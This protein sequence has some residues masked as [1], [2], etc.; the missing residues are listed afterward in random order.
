MNPGTRTPAS[1]RPQ[2][3]GK[4]PRPRRRRKPPRRR[5]S[6]QAGSP[7]AMKRLQRVRRKLIV[8]LVTVCLIGLAI[9]FSTD[10]I[11]KVETLRIVNPDG[12]E[13]PDT[14][15]YSQEE[16]AQATGLVPGEA[17]FGV[18]GDKIEQDLLVAL[19][20]LESVAVKYS[21]PTTIIL[22]V[23]PA[24]ES[25]YM[26]LG[27]QYAILSETLRVLRITDTLPDGLIQLQATLGGEPQVGY[28]LDAAKVAAEDETASAEAQ[29]QNQTL[30]QAL[31]ELSQY[32]HQEDLYNRV[33]RID[34]QD[35]ENI[36]VTISDRI[37]IQLGTLNN[38]DYKFQMVG[39]IFHNQGEDGLTENDVG[40]LD[41]SNSPNTGKAYYTPQ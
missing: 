32:L 15:I 11:F 4:A 21:L 22:E 39:T 36:T 7:A 5:V 2:S 26:P 19:P 33:T 17:L 12:T 34:L 16:I 31:E 29:E 24:V 20:Y 9:L 37:T 13:P 14:G 1:S 28:S 30:A 18:N 8:L 25:L 10:V 23:T 41:V 35:M 40:T 27:D 6:Y 38:L 3:A